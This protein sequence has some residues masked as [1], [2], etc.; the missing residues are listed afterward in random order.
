MDEKKAVVP[1]GYDDEAAFLREA[2]ERYQE[3]M[4]HDRDNRDAA[5]D[6]QRFLAGD[7]WDD[8][9]RQTRSDQGRPCLTVNR[10]PQ[11]VA[12]IVGDIRINRPAIRVRPAEDAD[13]QLAETREGI[14]RAIERQCDAQGAYANAAQ[15]QVGCGIGNFRVALDYASDDVFDRDIVIRHVP[16]PFS[17]V[18][19]SLSTDPTGKDA[20]FCFV[21]EEVA[22]KEF[23]AAYG[24][25]T[26]E[27]VGETVQIS[28]WVE[29]DVVRV[30]EY[31]VM[32]KTPVELALMEDG[33]VIRV[34]EVPPGVEPVKTRKS[35]VRSACMYLITG[36]RILEG[37]YELPI[38]RLP[39]FRVEGWVLPVEGKRVRFGLVRFAKDPQRLLNYWRSVSAEVLAMA[40]KS[41][42]LLHETEEGN[43]DAFRNAHNSGDPV[44]TWNGDVPPQRIDPPAIP[45]AVLQEAALNA[46]DMKDVTGLHDASLGARSNETSGKAILARQRE[47]DVA[48]FIYHDNLHAAIRECGVVVNALIPV[49]YDTA[50]T[51]RTVGEDNTVTTRR[52][53]D[54]T[55]P[56]AVDLSIGKYDIAVE[57]GPSFSTRRQEAAESMMQFA[58]AAPMTMQVAGDLI[59]KAMDW[60]MADDISERLKRA[61]PPQLTQDENAPPMQPPP[62]DPMQQMQM[63]A[64]QQKIMLDLQ[65][66]EAKVSKARADAVRAEAEATKSQLEAQAMMAQP[67]APVFDQFA[68]QAFG[69]GQQPTP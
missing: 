46:Q 52:V 56:Q 10:L 35:Y 25:T 67:V 51:L 3:A 66:Q 17:V 5:L 7:Q 48:S 32:K 9:V 44:L 18:W 60:P 54:P 19:D 28:D 58:Q 34:A 64:M 47:G 1:E 12:Q 39:V 24:D 36:N 38:P 63:Q 8:T 61:I 2:R 31:W 55:N 22:R 42:W 50:R 15:L 49:V 14:I 68:N 37:P 57:A 4:D 26:A 13:V 33:S 30:A 41:Q 45:S 16:D 40:P 20:R 59:A 11:F 29:R 65:E 53:N 69:Q 6:D 43:Q 23:E 27:E 62:P 21:V